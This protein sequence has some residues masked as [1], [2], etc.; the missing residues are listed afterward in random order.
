MSFRDSVNR[1]QIEE[2]LN[3]LGRRFT[4]AGQVYLVGGTT[5]VYEGFRTQTLDIDLAFDLHPTDHTEFFQVVRELKEELHV[6]VK[7]TS[8]GHFI[9]L[10]SSYETRFQFLGRYGKL[11]VFHFDPYSMALS[12]I[13]R[14]TAEDFSDVLSLLKHNWIQIEML[15]ETFRE[16]LPRYAIESLKGDSHE[17][18]RKFLAL[19]RMWEVE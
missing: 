4:G 13:E 12:K 11:E 2:F 19:K 16:I 7:E 17:F 14:A 5:M 1:Q 10:P 15:G 3:Q 18:E 9:P 8:P 6:K